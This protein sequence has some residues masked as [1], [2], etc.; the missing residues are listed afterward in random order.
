MVPVAKAKEVVLLILER[1]DSDALF[2][3]EQFAKL[4]KTIEDADPQW[5]DTALRDP[6]YDKAT[7]AQVAAYLTGPSA[8]ELLLDLLA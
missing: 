6:K 8:N 4:V 1:G 3:R 5:L 7:R 2:K